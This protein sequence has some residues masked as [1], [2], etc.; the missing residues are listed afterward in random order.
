MT[1][2]TNVK[3]STKH[4]TTHF[5]KFLTINIFISKLLLINKLLLQLKMFVFLYQNKQNLFIY[6]FALFTWSLYTK[7]FGHRQGIN[8]NKFDAAKK[9]TWFRIFEFHNSS[10]SSKIQKPF[11]YL[12]SNKGNS[13]IDFLFISDPSSK[14]AIVE[15]WR[16]K[17]YSNEVPHVVHPEN[18][19]SLHY[20]SC[21]Y[22][23]YNSID[24]LLVRYIKDTKSH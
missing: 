10:N 7:M 17:L 2:E 12:N 23:Y 15:Q 14:H 22:D 16:S 8:S 20:D 21:N 13:T 6:F 3:I 24:N 1:A 11:W 5:R 9:T 4:V 19:R 18:T